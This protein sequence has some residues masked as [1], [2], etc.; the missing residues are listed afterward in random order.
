MN[1][2]AIVIGCGRVGF[3]Y[4]LDSKRKGVYSHIAMYKSSEF[5]SSICAVDPDNKNL[6]LIKDKHSDILCFQD[7]D[8][9]LKT[10]KFDIA[11]VCTPSDIRLSVIKK[12]VS[13]GVKA[14][15]C[16]KPI[17]TN[18]KEAKRII[19][20]CKDNK[21]HLAVNHY[22]R[23]DKFHKEAQNFLYSGQLGKIQSVVV[24]YNN[25]TMNTGTHVFD[26]LRM[27]F[28]DIDKVYAY[29]QPLGVGHKATHNAI[30]QFVS[31]LNATLVASNSDHFRMFEIDIL[32][33][34]GRLT[35]NNGYTS[36][37]FRITQSPHNSE[38]NVLQPANSNF[39]EGR[40]KHYEHALDNLLSCIGG[41]E[42]VLS[43]GDDAIACL[44]ACLAIERSFVDKKWVNISSIV[45]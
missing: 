22:R 12:L 7:L 14:I 10:C 37:L 4:N 26:N 42:E 11:S 35:I 20:I 15:F 31:G 25:G 32:G 16:E 23:W 33:T 28:G 36:Q 1:C 18:L 41:N 19:K 44:K 40:K 45:A 29:G 3:T 38:F 9:A 39:P 2:S 6:L 5:I 17:S 8:K 43:S 34:L 24:H 13:N 27:F 21:I 30:V